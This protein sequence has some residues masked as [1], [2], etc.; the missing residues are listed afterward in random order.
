[1]FDVC[2]FSLPTS[3][4]QHQ[5]QVVTPVLSL[6]QYLLQ[7]LLSLP[8]SR[9][10][11]S[12]YSK[13]VV[14]SMHYI[15]QS[16]SLH[17]FW[18]SLSRCLINNL[19]ASQQSSWH[20]ATVTLCQKCYFVHLWRGCV[21]EYVCVY[22]KERERARERDVQQCVN[23]VSDG[24]FII[25]SSTSATIK[26]RNAIIDPVCFGAINESYSSIQTCESVVLI[27]SL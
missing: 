18:M 10:Q 25:R 21:L 12:P 3:K 26:P 17:I 14:I 13:L 19:R 4:L 22:D 7:Y 23:P 1:M 27:S 9:L 5:A 11:L 2:L 8:R 16:C 20:I 24:P 15:S 6:L